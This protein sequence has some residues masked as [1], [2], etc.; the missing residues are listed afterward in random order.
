MPDKPAKE[1]YIYCMLLSQT[2][3]RLT[4]E[5]EMVNNNGDGPLHWNRKVP[6]KN[7]AHTNKIV[8]MG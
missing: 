5:A 8:S 6:N 2:Y 1:P 7:R 3:F 4:G